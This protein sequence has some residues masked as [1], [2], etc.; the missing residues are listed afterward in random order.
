MQNFL[1]R[2]LR[3]LGLAAAALVVVTIG[4]AAFWLITLTRD[5]PSLETLKDY[6]PPITTRVYAG[7]GTVLASLPM[8]GASSCR[9]PSSP[10]W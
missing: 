6:E 5:L 1:P 7:N 3:W 8:S 2:F 9:P 10:S 4:F